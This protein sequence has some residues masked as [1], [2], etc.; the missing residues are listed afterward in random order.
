M[1]I[2]VCVEVEREDTNSDKYR[3]DEFAHA[4]GMI[5]DNRR[6]SDARTPRT[7]KAPR[8]KSFQRVR[9]FSRQLWERDASSRRFEPIDVAVRVCQCG[10]DT[11]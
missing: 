9:I 4:G 6:E 7:P 5:P 3:E 11:G 8:A 10:F 1:P 2:T